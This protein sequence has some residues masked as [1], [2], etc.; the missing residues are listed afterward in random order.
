M[1][2]GMELMELARQAE[3][4]KR[5]QAIADAKAAEEIRRKRIKSTIH[6]CDTTLSDYLEKAARQGRLTTNSFCYD[7]DMEMHFSGHEDI[8]GF[9]KELRAL[10]KERRCYANGDASYNVTGGY[11][12]TETI[13]NYCKEHCIL[14]QLKRANYKSYGCGVCDGFKLGFKLSPECR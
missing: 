5:L 10:S 7:Y 13:I 1:K 9:V 3:E 11:L 14:V 4:Q 2:C 12:D 8:H 6:W